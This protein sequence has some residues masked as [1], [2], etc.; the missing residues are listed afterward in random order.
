[1]ID[2]WQ[3]RTST[4]TDRFTLDD[5]RA[6]QPEALILATL[7]PAGALRLN[8][9]EVSGRLPEGTR[10]VALAPPRPVPD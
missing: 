3:V 8:G 10:I 5:W 7:S 9:K 6:R 2:G 4:L 1:M